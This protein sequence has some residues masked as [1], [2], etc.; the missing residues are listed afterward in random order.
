M[1]KIFTKRGGYSNANDGI[2]INPQK[3]IICLS[4]EL[5]NIPKFVDGK[6]TD[7]IAGYRGEHLSLRGYFYL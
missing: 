6:R 7:E 1:K 3:D 2:Y 5:E 4:T